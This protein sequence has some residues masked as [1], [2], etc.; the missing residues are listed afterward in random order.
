M[1]NIIYSAHLEF[2]LGLRQISHSLPLKIYQTSREHYYDKST[3]KNVAVQKV[4]FK[5]KTREMA[6]AYEQKLDRII[7]ITIHPLKTLQKTHRIRSGRWQ[8]I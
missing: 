1:K 8:E 4:R 7:I 6:V 2:R 3:G 5:G